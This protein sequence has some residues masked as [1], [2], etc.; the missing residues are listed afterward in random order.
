MLMAAEG[1]SLAVV[2]ERNDSQFAIAAAED[3]GAGCVGALHT[4]GRVVDGEC[5]GQHGYH[6]HGADNGSKCGW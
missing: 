4:P 1:V 2:V 6:G 3:N 5:I